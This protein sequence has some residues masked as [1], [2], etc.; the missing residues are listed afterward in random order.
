MANPRAFL[1]SEYF[2]L[3][4]CILPF[5]V[6]IT[7]TSPILRSRHTSLGSVG[8]SLQRCSHVS[9]GGSAATGKEQEQA[10]RSSA[11]TIP[12]PL[13]GCLSCLHPRYRGHQRRVACPGRQ[14]SGATAVF[15]D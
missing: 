11:I 15:G 14:R 7:S 12:S 9:T 5:F 3:T 6:P 8:Y 1:L 4:D 13:T 2:G 10:A